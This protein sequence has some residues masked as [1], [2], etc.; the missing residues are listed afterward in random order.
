MGRMRSRWLVRLGTPLLAAALV[1]PALAPFRGLLGQG[2]D[3]GKPTD[4]EPTATAT[5]TFIPTST[6]TSTAT[7]TSTPT[8]NPVSLD[9]DG[10]GCSDAEEAGS[11]PRFGGMRDPFDPWDFF[12]TP[13]PDGAVTVGDIAQ[14]V[15]RFGGTAGPPA[16]RGYHQAYDR[17]L[18]GPNRWNSGP[19]DGAVSVADIMVMVHQFGHTCHGP[20]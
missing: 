16:V 2:T 6:T 13:V 11:L 15:V 18:A 10:D 8:P 12:D 7:P 1:L 19:P 14:A 3:V 9:S 17:T 4:P 5:A 20:T